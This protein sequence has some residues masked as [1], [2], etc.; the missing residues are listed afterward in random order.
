MKT[1]VSAAA[2]AAIAF[3]SLWPAASAK[4]DDV[5]PAAREWSQARGN[6]GRTA[7]SAV[8][9]LAGDPV[10]AWKQALP[11]PV[12]AEPVSWGGVVFVAAQKDKGRRLLAFR[13]ATGEPLGSQ[14]LGTGGRMGLAAWQGVVMAL[15]AEQLRSFRHSGTKFTPGWSVRGKFSGPP[16][17]Y[18]GFAFV[19][20]G[21]DLLCLDILRNGARAPKAPVVSPTAITGFDETKA[22]KGEA[23]GGAV[24]VY[25]NRADGVVYAVNV[26]TLDNV[27]MLSRTRVDDLGGKTQMRYTQTEV[28]GTF[29]G[30]IPDDDRWDMVPCRIEGETLR[31]PGAW[32]VLSPRPFSSG[33]TGRFVPDAAK[34]SGLNLVTAPAVLD[35]VAFSFSG[36][37]DLQTWRASGKTETLVQASNAPP[38]AKPGPA[39]R[40]GGV[41]FLGNFAVDVEARRVI[42]SLKREPVTAAIPVGDKRLVF[43]TKD[44]LVCVADAAVI[45]ETPVPEATTSAGSGG[46]AKAPAAS[47]PT[48]K[49]PGE[50]KDGVLLDDGRQIEGTFERTGRTKVTIHPKDGG[51]SFEVSRASV[52]VAEIAGEVDIRGDDAAAFRVWRGAVRG[53]YCDTMETIFQE[54]AKASMLDDARR[55]MQRMRD[56]GAAEARMQKLDASLNGKSPRTDATRA[57]KFAPQ[58][59]AARTAMLDGLLAGSEWCAK[60][61]LSTAATALLNEAGRMRGGVDAALEERAKA[62]IPDG[63]PWKSAAD[64]TKQ[65]MKWADALLPSSSAF[66][67]QDDG[68]WGKFDEKP[69]NDGGT[70]GFRTRNVLLFIRDQDPALCGRALQLSEGTVRALQVFLNDGEADDVAGDSDRLEIRIHRNKADYLAETTGTGRKTPEWSAGN[71][72]PAEKISRFYVDRDEGVADMEELTRVLTHEFT[73]HYMNVRWMHGAS[74][75]GAGFWVVE[76]M[77]EFVQYQAFRMDQRGLK[78]DDETVPGLDG[79]AQAEKA[80]ALFKAE[81]FVDMTQ[82]DFATLQDS[83]LLTVKLRNSFT[84]KQYTQRGLWYE[85]AGALSFFFLQAKG[86]E[87][88]KNFVDYVR[89]HY[90]GRAPTPGWSFLGYDS[91]EALDKDFTDYLKRLRGG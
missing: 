49:M 89:L 5:D 14:D 82:A 28:I 27:A 46:T 36:S 91:A 32:I 80:G 56:S 22:L 13:A 20:D 61:E 45:A 30:A 16:C 83:Y 10:E 6:S 59:E 75:G 67:P 63:F 73:H 60:R 18:R 62:Q 1:L 47:A 11:G 54:Y 9:P 87:V 41:V 17:V 58:E 66:I 4:D 2:A 24:G 50:M 81:K 68:I 90:Q 76:G 21:P 77:A 65:W 69:W 7:G 48:M 38:G 79:A 40:A 19:C 86:P 43:A 84:S 34:A 12:I 72:S 26:A 57:K 15:D 3:A 39:T 53:A 23:V 74:G 88:R 8:A 55:V 71:F 33:G 37:G 25:R 64:A 35:A 31:S 52:V 44:E 51:E 78:F 29:P 85:Q 70:L 42:W